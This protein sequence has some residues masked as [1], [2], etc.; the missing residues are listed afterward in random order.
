MKL[1][2]TEHPHSRA[3]HHLLPFCKSKAGLYIIPNL[4]VLLLT[5]A[6]TIYR[7]I[8]LSSP[9]AC[10][11]ERITRIKMSTSLQPTPG[12]AAGT[13]AKPTPRS[14]PSPC[15]TLASSLSSAAPRMPLLSLGQS[16]VN[17]SSPHSKEETPRQPP[18]PPRSADTASSALLARTISRG[19]TQRR[20][21]G[22]APSLQDSAAEIDLDAVPTHRP[23]QSPQPSPSPLPPPPPPRSL[24]V[25]DGYCSLDLLLPRLH[26]PPAHV[27]SEPT[28]SP[29]SP[30]A[31]PPPQNSDVADVPLDLSDD[32]GGSGYS[33][34]P[35]PAPPPPPVHLR[36][37]PLLSPPERVTPGCG[38]H[39][40][41]NEDGRR[42]GRSRRC[43]ATEV[44]VGCELEGV[45][46]DE[47]N[48]SVCSGGSTRTRCSAS[49]ADIVAD[50]MFDAEVRAG[51]CL[52]VPYAI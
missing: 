38:E 25:A 39:T 2:R 4:S 31:P 18:C 8:S 1:V 33:G 30:H 32:E 21:A 5:N 42:C 29:V 48:D 24:A 44:V 11:L 20:G 37:H 13:R 14:A 17:F 49:T 35:S 12:H 41:S 23:S 50:M 22:V 3:F 51:W 45:F 47:D 40:S 27:A 43:E 52:P 46:I 9:I 7:A 6:V 34:P 26:D 15:N 16:R 28:A 10:V 36:P 19:L